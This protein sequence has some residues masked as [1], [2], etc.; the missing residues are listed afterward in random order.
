MVNYLANICSP[1][2][3]VYDAN[4]MKS[5]PVRCFM[6]LRN[7]VTSIGIFLENLCMCIWLTNNHEKYKRHTFVALHQEVFWCSTPLQDPHIALVHVHWVLRTHWIMQHDIFRYLF[8]QLRK[9]TFA[10]W[11]SYPCECGYTPTLWS[12]PLTTSDD[13]VYLTCLLLASPP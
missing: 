10:L 13:H 8:H 12:M 11:I 1:S 9:E 2:T 4:A 6:N 7:S 3:L 5:A